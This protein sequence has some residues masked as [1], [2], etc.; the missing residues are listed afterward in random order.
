MARRI[1]RGDVGKV[2]AERRFRASLYVEVFVP[3]TDDLEADR[4]KAAGKVREISALFPNNI[5]GGVAA[6]TGNPL[7]PLDRDI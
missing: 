4:E 2:G 7:R 3:E 6:F 1:L 5:V